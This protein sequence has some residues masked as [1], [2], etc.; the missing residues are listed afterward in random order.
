MIE[1]KKP[2]TNQAIEVILTRQYIKMEGSGM[3]WAV[4]V[5]QDVNE[6]Q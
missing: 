3:P 5:M 2:R 6:V 1:F 4:L